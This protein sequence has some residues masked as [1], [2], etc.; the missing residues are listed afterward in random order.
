MDK[1]ILK[2]NTEIEVQQMPAIGSITVLATDVAAIQTLKDQLTADNLK[3]VTIKNDAGNTTGI[4][5]DLILQDPWT[6]RWT[7]GGVLTTFGLREKTDA[8]KQMEA[9]NDEQAIQNGA[10]E[11]LGAVVSDM[12]MGGES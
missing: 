6:I 1:I 4:Y 10:I 9:V 11:E 2:D 5:G 8:E 7:D 3:E 12:A